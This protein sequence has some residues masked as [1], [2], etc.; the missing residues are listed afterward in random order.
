MT[1]GFVL[2]VLWTGY[3][4]YVGLVKQE[5]LQ[6]HLAITWIAMLVMALL[7]PFVF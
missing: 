7:A 1:I 3:L 2:C 5:S 6:M 4:A